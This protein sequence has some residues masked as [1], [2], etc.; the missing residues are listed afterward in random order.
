M[1][2]LP[3]VFGFL[4]TFVLTA[5]L[6]F[7]HADPALGAGAGRWPRRRRRRR[8]GRGRRCPANLQVLSKDMTGPRKSPPMC[9]AVRARPWQW[10][11]TTATCRRRRPPA[12]R[13]RRLPQPL[14]AADEA[15]RR[16]LTSRPTT[17]RKRR[18]P[19]S[20]LKMVSTVPNDTLTGEFGKSG[21][22]VVKV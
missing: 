18:R 10:R 16:S 5:S 21:S 12:H 2:R 17:S 19:A 7:V 15:A 20:V 6:V 4:G 3:L 13:P 9:R 14:E 22:P 11:A 8:P 1:K